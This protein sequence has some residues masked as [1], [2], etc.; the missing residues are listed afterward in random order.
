[1]L[2]NLHLRY[3]NLLICFIFLFLFFKLKKKSL[4]MSM[5]TSEPLE[6][7]L[8]LYM[9]MAQRFTLKKCFWIILR[10]H[11]MCRW[12]GYNLLYIVFSVVCL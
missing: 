6:Y 2:Q 3:S 1:M 10:N 9:F 7:F 11:L 8:I 4:F 12:V 5:F